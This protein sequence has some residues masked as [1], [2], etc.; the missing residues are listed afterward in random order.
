MR[1]QLAVL[2]V[3]VLLC[4]SAFAENLDEFDAR[5]E[6]ELGAK[7]AGALAVWK[8]ANAAREASRHDEAAKL[9]ADV[10]ARVPTF[11]HALRRQAGEELRGGHAQLAEQH[12]RQAVE[13]ERSAENLSV[14][15]LVLSENKATAGQAVMLADEA[16][17]LKSDD[18][19]V[20]QVLA[21]SASRANNL[22]L[23]RTA[24]TRMETIAPKD[25]RTHMF[26]ASVALSEGNYDE[27]QAA[28]DR[29][30]TFGLPQTD[31]EEWTATI[32]AAQPFYARW[33]KPA[34]IVFIAWFGGFALM[35]I[36]GA[37]LS[38]M[39]MEAARTLDGLS[40][41]VRRLY[42]FV[43]SASC[44]FYYASIPIVIA[45]VLAFSGGLI[46]ATFVL[47]HVP[48]K[49]VLL[50]AMLAA[51]SVWSMIKSF[52]V[53]RND[54][55]PGLRLDLGV[56]TKMRALL[57]S[58]A[59]KIG[60]RAV[61][62]V[63]ITPGTE[64]AVM[65]RGKGREKERC[66]I[67]GVAALDGLQTR[68]FKAILGHEYGHFTNRDTS[69]G[70][71]ALAVRN[72]LATTAVGLA[73]GGV[74]TWYNP[75]WWFVSGFYRLFLRIS[76]G[77]SRLQEVLADRWAVHAY[78]AAA[79]ENG[80]R[81]VVERGVR[82]DEHVGVTLKEVVDRRL[83]LANLYT[84]RSAAQTEEVQAR[85]EESLNR[86][87]SAYDSHPAPAERFALVHALPQRELEAE[88]DDDAPA[89]AL[90]VNFE[91]L[92]FQMTAQVR[93]NVRMNYGVE[94]AGDIA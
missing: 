54:D 1:K 21:M 23:L 72:S 8:Q 28:V 81:H 44:V 27:A 69:G 85:V 40:A 30:K 74:A 10:L 78:G 71:F 14:L 26:R 49:L 42:A 11:V 60:T 93:E 34:L 7:D 22:D 18:L 59:A 87:S 67:L 88:P 52:F 19:Y 25:S 65:E 33:W 16:S 90:F 6:R 62:N 50:L 73:Q 48:I 70:T 38:R 86:K 91:A 84:Y 80:L 53:R 4:L 76:E 61:D 89:T 31:Y 32:A 83:P 47:G 92:Q 75:A 5:L 55:D 46:Y 17:R 43:L 3:V 79:F 56:E 9:Y 15:A 29:A 39:A 63:Y 68:P 13:L 12:A 64:V 35:L 58:V 57:D 2:F 77:A 37:I 51:V 45:F 82:F 36:A 94:I 41:K 24:T 20:Q 66:L